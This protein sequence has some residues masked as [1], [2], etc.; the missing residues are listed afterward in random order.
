MLAYHYMLQGTVTHGDIPDNPTLESER[1][2]FFFGAA[3]GIPTLY[4]HH[5]SGNRLMHR[6]LKYCRNT[7]RSRRYRGFLRIP[8]IEYQL[9]LVRLLHHDGRDLVEMLRLG[10][11]L[12][13]LE[14]RIVHP[15]SNAVSHRIVQRIAGGPKRLALKSSGREFNRAAE[16][17]YR[18]DL[19]RQHTQEAYSV[20]RGAVQALDSWQSWRS[21][22]YNQQLL[23]ILG[24]RN[25]VDFVDTAKSDVLSEALAPDA[26]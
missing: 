8:G 14:Q 21:G 23:K 7:R 6:I 18:E 26:C 1:R 15:K 17:Y 22:R 16:T 9:A 3:I 24:G 4:L 13:D 20:F 10:H 11:V 2:Q 5:K 19:R 12:D 25:A